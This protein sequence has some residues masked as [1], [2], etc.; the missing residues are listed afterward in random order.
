MPTLSDF[1][2]RALDGTDVALAAYA[3]RVVLVVNTASQCGYASQLPGLQ[4]LHDDYAERGFTVLGFPSDQ[5]KQEPLGDEEMSTVCERNY[6]VTFPM[7]AKVSVNG[8]E[9]HPVYKWLR[10][11]KRGVL[12]GRINWNF[13]KFLVDRNGA[14]IG[15][16]GPTTEPE[17]LAADI[18]LALAA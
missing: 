3:G 17:Q 8:R 16:Y 11:Q 15:R 1:S 4:G 6:G 10:S 12:G 5:F 18:E 14:V 13:T 2:A 7:F 9:T